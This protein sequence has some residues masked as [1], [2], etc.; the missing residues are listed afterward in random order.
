MTVM[1]LM[2]GAEGWSVRGLPTLSM[3]SLPSIFMEALHLDPAIK[4]ISRQGSFFSFFFACVFVVNES[5][6][7][8]L[9]QIC[10]VVLA[11]AEGSA[12]YRPPSQRE[13]LWTLVHLLV[14]AH[15]RQG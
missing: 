12:C 15:T 14:L 2:D 3:T 4:E 8:N 1:E 6:F 9:K 5:I 11:N 10:V 7:K 13:L